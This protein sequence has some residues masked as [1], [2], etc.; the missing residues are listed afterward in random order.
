MRG[1]NTDGSWNCGLLFCRP[2]VVQPV[3]PCSVRPPANRGSVGRP[4][5]RRPRACRAVRRPEVPCRPRSA[6]CRVATSNSDVGVGVIGEAAGDLVVQHV[7]ERVARAAGRARDRRR[8]EVVHLAVA[9]ADERRHPAA[10]LVIDLD[11]ELVVEVLTPRQRIEVVRRSPARV[12]AGQA[13][14][15]LLRERRDGA[16]RDD[17]V[18]VDLAGQRV[19]DRLAEIAL[20][21]ARASGCWQTSTVREIWRKPS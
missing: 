10:E 8:L 20:R 12:G 19:L 18:G 11:V 13:G 9:D 15:D 16:R 14:K 1:L 21:A 4:V 2:H 17:A 3:T 5:C 6:T 7:H